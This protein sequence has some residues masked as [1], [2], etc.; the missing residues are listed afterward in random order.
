MTTFNYYRGSLRAAIAACIATNLSLTAATAIAQTDSATDNA[1]RS[2]ITLEEVTVTAQRREQSLQDVSLSISAIS[3][4]ALNSRGITDSIDLNGVIPGLKLNYVGGHVQTFVRGVGDVT[5]NGY[6]QSS[7]SLNV[8]GVYVGRTTAFRSIFFDT[9]RVEVLRG[10]Q[11]TLYGRNSSGGAI[12][13]LSRNPVLGE[14]NGYI[15]LNAGNYNLAKTQAA[16]NL[17]FSDTLAARVSMQIVDREGYN[18][19]GTSDNKSKSGRVKLLWEPSSQISLVTSME[20]A[21]LGG[22]GAGRVSRPHQFGDP[23]EGTTDSRYTIDNFPKLTQR[24]D[25]AYMDADYRAMSTELNWDLSDSITITVLPAYRY[26]KADWAAASRALFAEVNES[27]QYSFEARLAGNAEGLTWVGGAYWFKEDLSVFIENDGRPLSL[28][29]RYQIQDI[30]QNGTEA[31]AIFGETTFDLT[32]NLRGI[33]GARYTEENRDKRGTLTNS[34]FLAGGIDRARPDTIVVAD[35]ELTEDAITWKIGFEYDLSSDSMVYAS[36]NYGFKSGGF[37]ASGDDIFDPEYVTAYTLGSKSTLMDGRLTLNLEAFLW[38]YEDQQVSFLAPNNGGVTTFI[39][40]NAGSSTIQGLS[41][42]LSYQLTENSRLDL[43]VEYLDATFDDFVY[44]LS[45][46]SGTRTPKGE[47]RPDACLSGG[48]GALPFLQIRDCSGL[49]I[50][51]APEFS[52]NARYSQ[53]FNLTSGATLTFATD[54]KFSTET[55]LS[56]SNFSSDN[57]KQDSYVTF[58]ASLTYLEPNEKWN[59]QAWVRNI[60]NEAVYLQASD[61]SFVEP[62]TDIANRSSAAAIAAPRTYGLSLK[63]NF[64]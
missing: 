13:V 31:W 24:P 2:P 38:K 28:A 21:K 27:D 30:P 34:V 63:Y 41:T 40:R 42:E 44:S 48:T 37:D 58:D 49:T 18:S 3:G 14:T 50:P 60:G 16:I 1:K 7:V 12:N 39:T 10:P 6:T 47:R 29:G 35:N 26:I 43:G 57:H 20:A 15:S 5:S 11:G 17:P 22:K 19:D 54:A 33:L 45:Q 51:H 8:D 9:D 55:F 53:D 61:N 59:L 36:A 56:A 52:G 64:D 4:D 32:E 23:W 46:F 25:P 62:T